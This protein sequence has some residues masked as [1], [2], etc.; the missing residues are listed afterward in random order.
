[1]ED[2]LVTAVAALFMQGGRVLSVS[3]KNDL[4]D[5]GLPGGKVDPGETPREALARESFEETGFILEEAYPI[6]ERVDGLYVVQTWWVSR[7][8]GTLSTSE[9]GVLAWVKPAALLTPAC[10]SFRA[11]NAI[12]FRYIG[13][14]V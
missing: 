8:S 4:H 3:R 1:M 9:A 14:E 12:L 6:F 11:Y 2:A 7:W 5:L 10:K 13:L